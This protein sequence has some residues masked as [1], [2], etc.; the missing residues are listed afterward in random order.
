MAEDNCKERHPL[1]HNLSLNLHT[2]SLYGWATINQCMIESTSDMKE[3]WLTY[4]DHISASQELVDK[5]VFAEVSS[6]AASRGIL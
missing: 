3:H 2:S 1:I 4:S 6:E 5:Y